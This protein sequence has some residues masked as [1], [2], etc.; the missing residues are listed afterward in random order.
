MLR[1][2][3]LSWSP[4][5][6]LLNVNRPPEISEAAPCRYAAYHHHKLGILGRVLKSCLGGRCRRLG[7]FLMW[8]GTAGVGAGGM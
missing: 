6:S 7:L 4:A 5:A 2:A 1:A 8:A 3:S